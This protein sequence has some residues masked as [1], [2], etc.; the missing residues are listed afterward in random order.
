MILDVNVVISAVISRESRSSTTTLAVDLAYTGASEVVICAHW[1][2]EFEAVLRLAW[3]GR[4]VSADAI[5]TILAWVVGAT[6]LVADPEVIEAVC[7]DPDDDDLIA[8]ARSHGAT[9]V[10]GDAD[11]VS[12]RGSSPVPI[13][14][15]RQYLD[16][17]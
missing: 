3:M 14:T 2:G 9:L 8:L 1:L 11:L 17:A 5:P 16:L 6:R 13:L 12:L 10:S 7:R 15:P 4:Y